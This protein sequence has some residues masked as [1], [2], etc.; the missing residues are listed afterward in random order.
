MNARLIRKLRCIGLHDKAQPLERAVS[1]LPPK[2]RA[3]CPRDR[4]QPTK[5][6]AG[7]APAATHWFVL[8]DA[9]DEE[10]RL[11]AEMTGGPP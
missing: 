10:G 4:L 2:R 6:S 1:T 8:D 5:G 11:C 7:Q 9:G 3:Q